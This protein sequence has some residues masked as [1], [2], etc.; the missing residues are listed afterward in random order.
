VLQLQNII[1]EMIAKGDTLSNTAARMC[2]EVEKRS[3]AICSVLTV[4]RLGF[5]HPLAGPSLPPAYSAALDGLK[6]GPNVG[7]CGTAA[8]LRAEVTVTDIAADVRWAAYKHLAI[9]LGLRACWS[10]PIFDALGE[11][12]GTFAFYF[13]ECRG[14]TPVER[15]IVSHCVH[16]C[17]IALERD[18]RMIDHERRAF[19]DALTGLPNRAAFNAALNE[20]NCDLPGEWALLILDLDNLKVSNDTFGHHAGD[21]LLRNAGERI[22][23]AVAPARAFRIGGDEFAMIIQSPT[24]LRDLEG[25]ATRILDALSEPADCGGQII[26]PSATVGGAIVTAGDRVAER[27]RQNA[28]F[29]LYHAKETG[30]GG[31]VR[32]WPGLGTNITRRL[33]DIREVDAALREGRIE[34]YYQPVVRLDTR[35]IVGLEALCRMRLGDRIVAAADFHEATKDVHVATALT[36]RMIALVAADLRAWIDLGIPIQHVGINVSSADINGGTLERVLATAFEQQ[37]V[38]L[39][40]VILEVTESVY[41]GD[42]ERSVGKSVEGLRAKGLKVSLDDFGTGYASLTHLLT[43]PV[44][45]IKI[46]KS[47]TDGLK[48]GSASMAIVEGVI[49]IAQKLDIRVVVEGIETEDQA[50]L[51]ETAGC[52][53]GQGYLF[54]RPVDRNST[55]ALLIDRVQRESKSFAL[56]KG[57][58]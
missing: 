42:G 44:D 4:D 25:L 7:S 28:D 24:M 11:P 2:L 39:Q 53:L 8:Y 36:A 10:S 13:R 58:A 50:S 20:L 40:H 47:F 12:I 38:P 26:V 33:S 9:P 22:V 57:T 15:E 21:C 55:T 16:L 48:P 43:V 27:V 34:A 49:Q 41:L 46:D 37:N 6:S 14:P 3:D 45:I 23:A 1:L 51:L 29:A 17:S 56:E 19:T 52:I 5:L 54:S 18:Q 30:R 32:Y 35:E 31:F